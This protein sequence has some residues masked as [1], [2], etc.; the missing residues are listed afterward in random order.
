M[1]KL[2]LAAMNRLVE[3]LERENAALAAMDLPRAAAML[4]EKTDALAALA[5]AGGGA[6]EH[7][8]LLPAARRVD[9]LARKNRRLL[10]RAIVAQQR[11]IGVV[12]A[13]AAAASVTAEP[14]YGASGRQTRAAGPMALSTRV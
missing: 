9:D 11:V 4:A 3:V 2:L 12:A 1:P 10:E 14:F 7:P 6:G 13:A 5:A 8:G